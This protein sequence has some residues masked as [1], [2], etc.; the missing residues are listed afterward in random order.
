MLEGLL[1]IVLVLVGF[2]LVALAVPIDVAA[3]LDFGARTRCSLRIGWLFGLVRLEKEI[4]T[5]KPIAPKKPKEQRKKR[6]TRKPSVAVVRRGFGLLGELLH[7]V[8]VRHLDLDLSVGTDDPA[9]T[10]EL[11]G[12]AAP[13]VALANAQPQTR[14]SLRPDFAGS[15]LEGL[16]RGE[17]CIVP[18]C[19][20][21]PVFGFVLSPEVRSWLFAHR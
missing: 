21:A 17:I 5:Q 20:V 2:T 7:R 13:I 14:V 6:V 8:R 1:W 18:I 12:F 9:S 4:G 10:G 11:V 3:Q 15:R 16:G 19:L